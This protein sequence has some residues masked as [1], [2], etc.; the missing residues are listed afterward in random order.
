MRVLITGGCGFVGRH[1]TKRFVDQGHCVVVVDSLVSESAK[2]PLD[3]P[4]HLRCQFEFLDMDCRK[5]FMTNMDSWDLVIHLAAIV[6]GRA[7]MENH[8]M[9]VAD[10]LAID[11]DFFSWA[12]KNKNNINHLIYFSSSA[13]YPVEHQCGD[14]KLD[15]NMINFEKTLGVPDLTY[16]WSKLTGEYLA[17]TASRVYGLK[18]ACYRPFSGYGEDQDEVY[19]FI[20]ILNRVLRKEDPV[21]IWSDATRDFIHI[22]D[23]VSWVIETYPSMT[24]GS[25]LNLGTGEGTSFRK[26]VEKM[27]EISKHSASILIKNEMP[28]GVYYRVSNKNSNFVPKITLDEGIARSIEYLSGRDL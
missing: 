14:T 12:V 22:E 13:A 27:L 6:G 8:P 17:R 16:G 5:F 2:A 1:F 3:W 19:P 9:S 11:A 25:A 28:Q 26:L 10:D 24:D 15:E 23:I 21:T 4:K 7:N 20:G 18:V